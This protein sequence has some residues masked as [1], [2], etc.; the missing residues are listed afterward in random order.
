M[1]LITYLR[2]LGKVKKIFTQGQSQKINFKVFLNLFIFK[3]PVINMDQNHTFKF[4][5]LL[6]ISYKIPFKSLL[7]AFDISNAIPA[8]IW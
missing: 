1:K 4:H 5:N 3:I 6:K 8:L 7:E 2:R